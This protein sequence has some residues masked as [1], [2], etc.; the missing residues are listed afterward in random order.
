MEEL[1]ELLQAALGRLIPH[2]RDILNFIYGSKVSNLEVSRR[3]GVAP[4]HASHLKIQ[5]L[6]HLRLAVIAEMPHPLAERSDERIR[7]DWRAMLPELSLAD[8][9]KLVR[10]LSDAFER[11]GAA[12]PSTMNPKTFARGGAENPSPPALDAGAF[13]VIRLGDDN[14]RSAPESVARNLSELCDSDRP[15]IVC[16]DARRVSSAEAVANWLERFDAV[17]S[18]EAV[19][20]KSTQSSQPCRK[21]P[22]RAVPTGFYEPRRVVLANPETYSCLRAHEERD[23]YGDTTYLSADPG[24][25][26]FELYSMFVTRMYQGATA[27]PTTGQPVATASPE[28]FEDRFS[29][30][31]KVEWRARI[32]ELTT[33]VFEDNPDLG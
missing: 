31:E 12:G 11:E 2:E 3:L 13:H 18:D 33:Q 26:P 28:R 24:D 30:A 25:D 4:G 32:H 22:D 21:A 7:R 19:A 17:L 29:D 8:L 6:T 5:A 14:Q 16:L 15:A 20:A 10:T 1:Y 9:G 23:L 27:P